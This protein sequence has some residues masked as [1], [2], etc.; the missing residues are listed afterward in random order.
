MNH[1]SDDLAALLFLENI[2]YMNLNL[3]GS[4]SIARSGNQISWRGGQCQVELIEVG[5]ST[6][7]YCLSL[8]NHGADGEVPFDR[9]MGI[10]Q[11]RVARSSCCTR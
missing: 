3:D 9:R 10:H 4:S 11:R 7:F 1:Y 2:L 8:P 6:S 5:F